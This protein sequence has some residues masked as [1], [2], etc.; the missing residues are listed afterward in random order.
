[1]VKATDLNVCL[2]AKKESMS[3]LNAFSLSLSLSLVNFMCYSHFSNSACLTWWDDDDDDGI[4]GT[5]NQ[6]NKEKQVAL[7]QLT[8]ATHM[9]SHKK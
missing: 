1:M 3:K 8:H 6:L 4:G 2:Q 7:T 5:S 9:P